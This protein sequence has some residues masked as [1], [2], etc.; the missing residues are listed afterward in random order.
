MSSIVDL[1][2]STTGYST[3]SASSNYIAYTDI[4][5]TYI[6][7]GEEQIESLAQITVSL[8]Y[9]GS[10][11]GSAG[12]EINNKIIAEFAGFHADTEMDKVHIDPETGAPEN[13]HW[14]TAIQLLNAKYGIIG[15]SGRVILPL[16][17]AEEKAAT[18]SAMIESDKDLHYT[19]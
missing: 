19:D 15:E 16:Y 4:T 1:F 2:R 11:S 6:P 8:V 7:F 3:D 9:T 14:E 12:N 5:G 10:L 17:L 18:Y 13:R